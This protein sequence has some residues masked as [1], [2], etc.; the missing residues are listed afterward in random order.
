KSAWG[1]LPPHGLH[2][3]ADE[4]LNHTAV[5]VLPQRQEERHLKP[6][7][8]QDVHAVRG[9][10]LVGQGPPSAKPL[11]EVLRLGGVGAGRLPGERVRTLFLVEP[12]GTVTSGS[13]LMSEP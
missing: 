2:G 3:L 9:H 5:Q 7:A 1:W 12:L 6:R 13:A 8:L 10:R 4:G 11:R